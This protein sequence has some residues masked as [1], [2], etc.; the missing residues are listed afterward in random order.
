MG[1]ETYP[2]K[3]DDELPRILW[4]YSVGDVVIPK[5]LRVDNS[6]LVAHERRASAVEFLTEQVEAQTFESARRF[7][8]NAVP[9]LRIQTVLNTTPRHTLGSPK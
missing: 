8:G 3:R 9:E 6:Q 4:D 5:H 7:G 2:R 1:L